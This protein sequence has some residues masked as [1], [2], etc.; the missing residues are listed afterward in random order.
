MSHATTQVTIRP[1]PA[2]DRLNAHGGRGRADRSFA[3]ERRV[4]PSAPGEYRFRCGRI[5]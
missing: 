4:P 1:E 5:V 3:E 2:R